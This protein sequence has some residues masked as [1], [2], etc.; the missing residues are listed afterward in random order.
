MIFPL[1]VTLQH[2]WRHYD[3]GTTAVLIGPGAGTE[4][5]STCGYKLVNNSRHR[6]FHTESSEY[7]HVYQDVYQ[8]VFCPSHLR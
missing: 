7:Q 5:R 6:S 4:R 3:H 8:E 2:R 1:S